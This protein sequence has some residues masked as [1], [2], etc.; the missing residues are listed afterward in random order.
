MCTRTAGL[1]EP[2]RHGKTPLTKPA[3]EGQGI[4]LFDPMR[5]SEKCRTE[6]QCSRSSSPVRLARAPTF[7]P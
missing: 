2:E 5:F 3:H 6:D 1:I 7:H 4:T